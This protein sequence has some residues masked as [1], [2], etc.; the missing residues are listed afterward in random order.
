MVPCMAVTPKVVL[1]ATFAVAGACLLVGCGGGDGVSAQALTGTLPE[2]PKPPES[3]AA[4]Y[5]P[6]FRSLALTNKLNAY[7]QETFGTP[8]YALHSDQLYTAAYRH[9]V[10]LNSANSEGYLG[11]PILQPNPAEVENI[12]TVVTTAYEYL[13]DE[14]W[15]PTAG[16]LFPALFTDDDL[17]NRVRAIAGTRDLFTLLGNNA[18]DVDEFYIFNGDIRRT[19]TGTNSPF[20]GFN[21][22]VKDNAD[23]NK[24]LYDAVDNVWYT[25][26]GRSV[27]ARANLRLFGYGQKDDAPRGARVDPP[28]PIFNGKFK[29]VL[30]VM[31][32]RTDA[33]QF[34]YWPSDN[35]QNVNP[36]GLDT[37]LLGPTDYVG[38]PIS[39]QL[40]VNEPILNT[41]GIIYF[42]MHKVASYGDATADGA[43]V[44]L[45]AGAGNAWRGLQLFS[46]VLGLVV[47]AGIGVFGAGEYR[48]VGTPA[49][50]IPNASVIAVTVGGDVAPPIWLVP[51]TLVTITLP[52][53]VDISTV[54]AGDTVVTHVAN[55][56]A[57][58]D[59]YWTAANGAGVFGTDPNTNSIIVAVPKPPWWE[60]PFLTSNPFI[61]ANV[62]NVWDDLTIDVFSAAANGVTANVDPRLRNGEFVVV[63]QAPL[64]RN[65]WYRV[66][67]ALR[68]A[69]QTFPEG[70]TPV[71]GIYYQWFFK[72]NNNAFS[73]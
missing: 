70:A 4:E 48:P 53:N 24:Y 9:A 35:H 15:V 61:P 59:L 52:P 50:T 65:A 34:G 17:G 1:A 45:P 6:A 13:R 54:A 44:V 72:T 31:W 64:E 33:N 2:N 16:A 39:F 55:G 30:D 22:D 47:P 28:Y 68:T 69:S 71:N 40:P 20:R 58:G 37:D 38:P 3:V 10:Y 36:Y 12:S 18:S 25:R 51:A 27:L 57:A 11:N 21:L 7:R 62:D 23:P 41:T 60:A 43:A 5:A 8:M 56:S 32:D 14:Q 42:T 73:P 49:P 29:G 63:P 46:N 19:D 26:R 67:L 66:R